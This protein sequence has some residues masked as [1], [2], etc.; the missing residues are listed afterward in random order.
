MNIYDT[1]SVP[2]PFIFLLPPPPQDL[3]FVLLLPLLPLPILL[4]GGPQFARFILRFV[5][6][7][8][9]A[10]ARAEEA[11]AAIDAAEAD[12]AAARSRAVQAAA[13]EAKSPTSPAA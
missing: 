9:A 4:F 5:P 8:A 7:A 12:A 6:G 3:R 13:F 1:I 2:V 10:A 11:A